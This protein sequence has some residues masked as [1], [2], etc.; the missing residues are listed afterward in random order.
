V[1]IKA[2]NFL[3]LAFVA[4]L[5][6]VFGHALTPADYRYLPDENDANCKLRIYRAFP[7]RQFNPPCLVINADA[8]DARYRYLDDEIVTDIYGVGDEL[9]VNDALQVTPVTALTQVRD[10]I[11]NIYVEDVDFTYDWEA[12]K[13][14]WIV[15]KPTPYY[16]TYKTRTFISRLSTPLMDRKVQSQIV[17]PIRITIYAMSTTDRERLTDLIVLYI[18]SV[19]RNKFKPFCTYANIQIGGD[20]QEEWENQVLYINTV[21]VTCWT[22]YASEIPMDIYAMIEAF[23]IDIA[24][25]TMEE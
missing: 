20:T 16:A 23:N 17:V 8:S 22:Q 9:V 11:N 4:S 25:Q 21:T 24:V 12:N 7:K 18:R 15:T 10:S 6:E 3:K 19:F 14:T 2:T 1:I 5:R 13:F